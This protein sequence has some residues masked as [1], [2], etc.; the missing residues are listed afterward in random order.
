MGESLSFEL[1]GVGVQ[2]LGNK[3]NLL[4]SLRRDFMGFPPNK[5]EVRIKIQIVDEIPWSAEGQKSLLTVSKNNYVTTKGWW[6]RRVNLYPRV[7]AESVTRNG[8]RHFWIDGEDESAMRE[9][10]YKFVLSSL[11]EE[12][13]LRGYHRVHGCGFERDG[14]RYLVFGKSGVGKSSLAAQIVARSWGLF[15]DES[16]LV[17]GCFLFAFPTR[18]SLDSRAAARLSV[19]GS[20]VLR[21]DNL[22]DKVLVPFPCP[23]PAGGDLRRIYLAEHGSEPSVSL[24]T[25][26]NILGFFFSCVFGL[27]LAQMAEWMLRGSA[28]PRLCLIFFRRVF[29]FGRLSFSVEFRK[30]QFNLDPSVNFQVLCASIDSQDEHTV[31]DSLTF[32]N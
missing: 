9:V 4:A 23:A 22:I 25:S 29:A 15:S 14:R 27:G 18:I 20:E 32:S 28:L 5:S 3:P 24:V 2:I 17:R 26:F 21:R 7:R 16:P 12:L 1:Q 10:I 6:N 30:A 31:L 19:S 11:G 13:E 8:V